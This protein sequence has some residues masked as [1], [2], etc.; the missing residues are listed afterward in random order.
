[1]N[2]VDES[3]S[4]FDRERNLKDSFLSGADTTLKEKKEVLPVLNLDLLN[5]T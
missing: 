4:G 3:L 5:L 1:V 2:V